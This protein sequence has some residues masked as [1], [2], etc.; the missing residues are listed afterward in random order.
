MLAVHLRL[1][2][3]TLLGATGVVA[4]AAEPAKA[5]PCDSTTF[6]GDFI[7]G[8]CE[9]QKQPALSFD[10]IFS[11][12]YAFYCKGDHPYFY[13][14]LDGY[15]PSFTWDNSCFSVAE[16]L[17]FENYHHN[18]KLDVTISNFCSKQEEIIV[19]LACSNI[20]PG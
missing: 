11:Q 18:S 6:F 16:N 8:D 20:D 14:L 2:S 9:L 3:V 10:S 19:T 13:G 17:F 4:L 12:G 15:T 5:D 1:I 7:P